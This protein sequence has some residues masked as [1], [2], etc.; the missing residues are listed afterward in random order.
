M[1]MDWHTQRVRSQ[2]S[3][4]IDGE[5]FCLKIGNQKSNIENV[6]VPVVQR[7]ERRFPK[8]KTPLLHQFADVISDP[9]LAVIE[10]ID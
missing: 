5:C 4:V 7:I 10:G 3:S 8:A 9:Q 6:V 1:V 2:I